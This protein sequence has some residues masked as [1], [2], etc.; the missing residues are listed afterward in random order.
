[1]SDTPIVVVGGGRAAASLVAAY[2]EAGGNT[3]VVLLSDE[4]SPPYNRPPLSKG[5][6]RGDVEAEAALAH[7][8]GFYEE[9]DVDLRLRSRVVAVDPD[10]RLVRLEHG[11]D[12]RYE[13]L[14]VATGAT[15][16]RL[17][18]PG[19]ELDGVT[20][21][22]TLADATAV[23]VKAATAERALVVGGSFIGAEVA[24]SLR[25]RGLGVVLVEAGPRLMPALASD[26]L[27]SGLLGLFREAG[28]EVLLGESLAEL[29]A[30]ARVLGGAV[31]ASGR[32]V[33][34]DL[35]VIGI[36]VAPN[37]GFL[38][39]SGIEVDDGVVVDESFRTSAANVFAVGDVARYPDPVSGRHRRIEHW[40][41]A[42]AQGAH[43]GRRLA[44][45][46]ERYD[47]VPVFFTQLFDLKFQV[48]GDT[49]DV[50]EVVLRGSV[51][52]KRLLGFALRSGRLVGAV[53][54]GQEPDVVPELQA[55]LRSRAE[56]G[57]RDRLV[58]ET[59]R[60]AAAFA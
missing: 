8:A 26:E 21:F 39:G 41:N 47:E 23:R 12:L 46:H 6:L 59:L 37:T 49:H 10:R 51:A 52:A 11:G 53:L 17:P 16:R 50:D 33:E 22:R 1:M 18:V 29:T 9:H 35:A 19:A 48:L 5:Y 38:E 54:A 55:L 45:S 13:T 32:R 24:A 4:P 7:P 15:P 30:E 14:V 25:L 40:S 28:V 3:A 44:G 58:D 42:N 43:L 2:R 56:P 60:P 27:S 20:V 31:T 57:D 34:A 36:G